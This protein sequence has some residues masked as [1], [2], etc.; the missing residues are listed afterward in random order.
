LEV[1]DFAH[2]RW[3]MQTEDGSP[4]PGCFVAADAMPSQA[5]LAMQGCSQP[6]VD[7]A[8]SETVNLPESASAEDI[9][10]FYTQAYEIG[11]KG[12]TV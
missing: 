12:Y 9:A 7:N 6:L 2:A 10:S 11:L 4:I 8:I 3:L 1:R 5:H